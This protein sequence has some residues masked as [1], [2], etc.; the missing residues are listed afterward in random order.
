MIIKYFDLQKELKNI[1][2]YLLY[3][4]NTGLIEE[5]IDKTLKPFFSKNLYYRDEKE[6]LANE[7]EFKESILNKSFFEKDKLIIINR[8]S[9]KI[10]NIIEEI[11]DKKPEELK[12]IL[13]SENLEK[14][15]KLRNF[16]EKEKDLVSIAF[17]SDTRQ[18]LIGI[19]KSF[20]LAKNVSISQETID[21]LVNR[22]NGDRKSLNNELDKIDSYIKNKKK[23][24]IEEIHELTNLS[25]N[26]SI[27]ELVD[28]CLAKNKNRTVHILNENNFSFE[29]AIIIIRTFLLKTKR[30][31]ILNKNLKSYKSIDQTIVSFKPPIF[32][33][34]KELVKMQIKFW[35]LD[36]TYKLIDEINRVELNIKKNSINSLN[37]LFDFILST[38]KTNN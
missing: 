6:I 35:T 27:N 2:Y 15:S 26:Y 24:T 19:A 21:L 38:S 4:P 29:D 32:W 23:I 10:L 3:G 28:N 16:F 8:A 5:I 1:N 36:K 12:I 25:E 37:I 33:K 14:K 18:S 13:K 7:D 17:Y 31:L 22:V 30:L 20:F 9:D 11:I 34:D